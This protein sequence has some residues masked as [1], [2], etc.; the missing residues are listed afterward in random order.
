LS[1]AEYYEGDRRWAVALVVPA[2]PRRLLNDDVANLQTDW[3]AI[4]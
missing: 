4:A 1:G 3:L 2:M